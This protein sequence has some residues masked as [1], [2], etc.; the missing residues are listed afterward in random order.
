M[1]GR[2]CRVEQGGETD[3]GLWWAKIDQ[4]GNTVGFYFS[5]FFLT[6]FRNIFF[7]SFL[8]GHFVI[9]LATYFQALCWFK[10]WK[11]STAKISTIPA[12]K[13]SK[14]CHV[15]T[16]S[17]TFTFCRFSKA[18][19]SISFNDMY[20]KTQICYRKKIIERWDFPAPSMQSLQYWC[21][22]LPGP[23]CWNRT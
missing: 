15:T 19:C 7:L 3:R 6:P 5:P 2:E 23:L 21:N 4:I 1:W 12:C 13:H 17:H 10:I 9:V 11:E 8:Y 22:Q 20:K 18:Q 14:T 16:W